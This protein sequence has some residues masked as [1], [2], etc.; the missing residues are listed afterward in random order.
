MMHMT[1]RWFGP[2]QDS[3]TLEQIHQV[4]GMEGVITALHEL[5]AGEPWP[6]DKV[7]ERKA[8]VEKAG[9]KLLGI[10][11]INVHEDIKYGAPT[12]DM[13]IENYIKSLEAVAKELGM[14]VERRKVPV[15]ELSTFEEVGECGTAVVITPVY[16]ID[17]KPALESGEVTTYNYGQKDRC[18]EKSLKLY[19]TIRGIQY[20]EI[21]DPFGWCMFVE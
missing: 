7:K 1:M 9:L 10:E 16:R 14:T 18:G 17:D 21:E 4:P 3:I 19:K 20:G 2:E 15:E 13:Y 6:E 12:R 11:S 8:M 5:P